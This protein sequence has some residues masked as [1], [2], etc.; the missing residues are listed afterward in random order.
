[1]EV[2]LKL[3]FHIFWNYNIYMEKML[4]GKTLTL[5]DIK[6][7]RGKTGYLIVS[8]NTG[9][10]IRKNNQYEYFI[11]FD[12]QQTY[13]YM[14]ELKA[15]LP[16]DLK[17]NLKIMPVRINDES[18]FNML[19]RPQYSPYIKIIG[20]GD[21]PLNE[22]V[23]VR[24]EIVNKIRLDI[25]DNVEADEPIFWTYISP[26]RTLYNKKIKNK[27]V[28][29][30][31]YTS[32][33]KNEMLEDYW[34]RM[35]IYFDDIWNNAPVNPFIYSVDNELVYGEEIC[36]ALYKVEDDLKNNN[37]QQYKA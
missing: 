16:K 32:M 5:E 33:P 30:C 14:K 20:Q 6:N 10:L 12:K 26:E 19:C 21:L 24:D 9:S 4:Y 36:T 22:I 28:T 35:P 11:G 18:S 7:Y 23:K 31:L 1:M 27:L 3:Y 25:I 37:W 17:K 34:V 2:F 15:V 8:G 13:D 29:Y